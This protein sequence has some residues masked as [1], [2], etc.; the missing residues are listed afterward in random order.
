MKIKFLLILSIF[1]DYE[2][3]NDSIIDLTEYEKMLFIKFIQ[4]KKSGSKDKV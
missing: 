3:I 4:M 1:I 2:N